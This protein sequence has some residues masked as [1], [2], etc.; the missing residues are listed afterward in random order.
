[1]DRACAHQPLFII[2]EVLTLVLSVLVDGGLIVMKQLL[3]L[4][5]SHY[6]SSWNMN[7][8]A[9]PPPAITCPSLFT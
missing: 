1:M 5:S 6:F 4:T 9:S 8:V 7:P 2:L 3:D